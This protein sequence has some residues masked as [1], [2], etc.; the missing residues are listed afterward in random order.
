MIVTFST[1]SNFIVTNSVIFPSYIETDPSS[2]N[3]GNYTIWDDAVS[4]FDAEEGVGDKLTRVKSIAKGAKTIESCKAVLSELFT[5]CDPSKATCSNPNVESFA[6]STEQVCAAVNTP[7]K[8][9]FET[10]GD[11]FD[12]FTDASLQASLQGKP[13]ELSIIR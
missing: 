6:L 5:V 9:K 13:K 11:E 4:M 7:I 10:V 3:F 1:I 2:S 12:G 8:L